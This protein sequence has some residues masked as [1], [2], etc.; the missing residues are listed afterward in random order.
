MAGDDRG[1]RLPTLD[2]DDRRMPPRAPR[3]RQ[4]AR[5]L[6]AAAR[7]PDILLLLDRHEPRDTRRCLRTPPAQRHDVAAGITLK[8]NSGLDW[9][10]H[11]HTRTR[12]ELVPTDRIERSNLS[13]FIECDEH[14][15]SEGGQFFPRLEIHV[16]I[17]IPFVDT[18]VESECC[19]VERTR[20]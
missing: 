10:R 19:C 6:D 16:R 17:R 18:R 15:L 7:K 9:L 14:R 5:E 8:M 1:T 13:R 2:Q 11:A 3:R 20:R 12:C 4:G